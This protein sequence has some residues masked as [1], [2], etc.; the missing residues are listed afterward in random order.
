MARGRHPHAF[1][2]SGGRAVAAALIKQREQ[3]PI[4]EQ[5]VSDL[6]E[7]LA[8]LRWLNDGDAVMIS[9]F[10]PKTGNCTNY[11]L[12]AIEL[13]PRDPGVGIPTGELYLC[14]STDLGTVV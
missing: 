1:A 8:E 7:K 12:T 11:P 10:D 2:R 6:R 5:M 9:I 13:D 4:A 3:Q 14:S